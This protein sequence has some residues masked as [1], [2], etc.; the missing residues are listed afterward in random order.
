MFLNHVLNHALQPCS[1]TILFNHPLQPS[2]AT[3]TLLVYCWFKKC[4]TTYFIVFMKFNYLCSL[5]RWSYIFVISCQH[6]VS[7][8]AITSKGLYAKVEISLK[9][10]QTAAILEVITVKWNWKYSHYAGF[11]DQMLSPFNLNLYWKP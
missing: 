5:C 7:Q 2:S 10:F 3:R 4:C 9:I 6:F 8:H 1:S 11:S